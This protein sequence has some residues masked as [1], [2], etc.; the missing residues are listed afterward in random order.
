M[1]ERH[2]DPLDQA[3]A[4][5]PSDVPPSRD[6]WEGIR[7]EIAKTPIVTDTAPVVYRHTSRWLQMAAGV[8][9]VL[10]TSV[11]TYVLTRQSMQR[12]TTQLARDTVPAPLATAT[13]VAFGPEALGADY[14]NARADLDRAF[15]QR[16]ATLPPATRAKLQRDLA[17][18][19]HAAREISD[20][21]AQHPSDPLLQELL[22]STYQRELQFLADVNNITSAASTRTDL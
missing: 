20:T 14:L 15:E 18:L 2:D 10:G 17:D 13:P 7:A 3:L 5:L 21:L 19:R 8:L 22:M 9:L 12:E 11:T 6:L 4:A 16:I 1:S